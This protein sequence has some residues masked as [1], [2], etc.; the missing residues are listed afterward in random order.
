[1]N[2]LALIDRLYAVL[3]GL[4][5][6]ATPAAKLNA[7]RAALTATIR[8]LHAAELAER[9]KPAGEKILT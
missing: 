7:A 8:E 4:D 1:M 9:T 3:D 6:D 5:G 2:R